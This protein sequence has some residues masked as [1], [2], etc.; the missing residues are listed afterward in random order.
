[1]R[2][3]HRITMVDESIPI[4]YKNDEKTNV[5]RAMYT[6]VFAVISKS[7]SN[8]FCPITLSNNRTHFWNNSLK[9]ALGVVF[10]LD[11][12]TI[13]FADWFTETIVCSQMEHDLYTKPLTMKRA[14]GANIHEQK[15]INGTFM[16]C[17]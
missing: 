14:Q 11:I 6:I 16:P 7:A 2:Q 10:D 8:T 5:I 15:W 9:L 1:M 13:D 12:F 3:I 4:V 17:N